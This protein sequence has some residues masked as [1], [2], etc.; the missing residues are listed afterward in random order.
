MGLQIV[1]DLSDRYSYDQK[2]TP[3]QSV[4]YNGLVES[5][6]ALADASQAANAYYM[7]HVNKRRML[8][9][10]EGLPAQFSTEE[11]IK[12]PVAIRRLCGRQS[13]IVCAHWF[14]ITRRNIAS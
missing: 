14:T 11:V 1:V 2:R 3:K 10:A 12:A 5:K 9:I 7:N 8:R 13:S 6:Q 4:E